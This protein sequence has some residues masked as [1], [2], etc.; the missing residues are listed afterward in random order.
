[1]DSGNFGPPRI[2]ASELGLESQRHP[3]TC[4][5]IR[6]VVEAVISNGMKIQHKQ[7]MEAENRSWFLGAMKLAYWMDLLVHQSEGFAV[8]PNTTFP[9]CLGCRE[10][11]YSS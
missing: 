7:S 4:T 1:M 10:M 5:T 3:S 11:D 2:Y 8:H 6:V 9:I